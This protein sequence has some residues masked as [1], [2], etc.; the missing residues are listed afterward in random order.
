MKTLKF[1]AVT[2]IALVAIFVILG[3]WAPKDYQ[4]ERSININAPEDIVYDHMVHFKKWGLW[5]P[6]KHFDPKM[7]E[8]YQGTDGAIGATYHWE[9]NK[10]VGE[11]IVKNIAVAENRME[12]KMIF[13]K[14]FESEAD[15]WVMTEPLLEGTKATWGFKAHYTFPYNVMMMF[16][17]MDKS[18]GGSF[19]EGLHLLKE[20]SEREA[21]FGNDTLLRK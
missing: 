4:L 1:L 21:K 19:E 11:G 14:P 12:Y 17:D 6:W 7:K 18:I 20:V 9:G 3:I 8:T 10:E 2:L 16:M 5:S 13:I 15:G